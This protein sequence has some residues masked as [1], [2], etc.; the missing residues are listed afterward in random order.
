MVFKSR[1]QR[2][3]LVKGVWGLL[4]KS[5]NKVEEFPLTIGFYQ[6]SVNLFSMDPKE[7]QEFRIPLCY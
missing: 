4:L 2:P 7:G 1:T 6:Y 5:L 3:R